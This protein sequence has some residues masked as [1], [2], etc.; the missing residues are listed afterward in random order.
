VIEVFKKIIDPVGEKHSK[1]EMIQCNR[2]G[3]V[4]ISW[5][6]KKLFFFV[7]SRMAT[8]PVFMIFLFG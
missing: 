1:S 2:R 4:T 8:F 3:P 7:S 5:E 6:K